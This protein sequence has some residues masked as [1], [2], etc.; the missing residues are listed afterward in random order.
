MNNPRSIRLIALASGI[1]VALLI[2]WSSI[3]YTV[4]SGYAGLIFR[5][6]SD[7]IDTSEAPMGQGFHFKAPWDRVVAYE[8]R[9]KESRHRWTF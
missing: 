8:V 2:S 6:F 5:T 1:F 4:P 7:G 9:Q 3:T